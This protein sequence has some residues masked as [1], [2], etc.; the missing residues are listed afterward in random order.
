MKRYFEGY[1]EPTELYRT[2]EGFYNSP[3][4]QGAMIEDKERTLAFQ[5]AI[6]EKTKKNFRVVDFGAG[7]GILSMFAA[8]AGAKK[9]YAVE[10]SRMAPIAEKIIQE[11]NLNQIIQIANKDI[12]KSKF[13]KVDLLMSECLGHLGYDEN[14]VGIFLDIRDKLLKKG[15]QIIPENLTLFLA[16]TNFSKIYHENI[17][18][19]EKEKYSF[20][21]QSLGKK[22][23]NH[24]YV[25]SIKQ[26]FLI[27][28]GKKIN[29]CDLKT[30]KNYDFQVKVEFRANKKTKIYGL[31]GWWESRLSEKII[32]STA[33]DK[34]LT[35]WEQCFLPILPTKVEK[36]DVIIAQFSVKRLKHSR[37]KFSW[38]VSINDHESTHLCVV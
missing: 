38:T 36:N 27:S 5:K 13:P 25:I 24:I 22:A 29:T 3:S 14:T 4:C 21:F 28:D 31:C 2:N 32:L 37:V 17:K 7:S 11:N 18:P 10:W 30:A 26:N 1:I 23:M 34:P 8:A 16:P 35:H 15:G 33:P 12:R 19:W 6:T 9:V 20:N